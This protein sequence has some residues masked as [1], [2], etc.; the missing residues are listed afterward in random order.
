MS[1]DTASADRSCTPD[2]EQRTGR[3]LGGTFA[4]I[5]MPRYHFHIAGL[6]VFDILGAVLPDTEAARTHATNLAT[7]MEGFR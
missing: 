1:K 2:I 4:E 3:R 5:T 7:N 6:K